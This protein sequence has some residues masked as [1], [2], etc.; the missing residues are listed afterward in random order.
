M[1]RKAKKSKR[2]NAI[3]MVFY[4]VTIF[5]LLITIAVPLLYAL[6][7]PISLNTANLVSTVSL[8][9]FLGT[10]AIS[11]M[12]H[13]RIKPENLTGELGL[14]RDRLTLKN[15]GYGILIFI[16][17][18]IITVAISEI[19]Q[20]THTS[21]NSNAASVLGIFPLW[22]LP[23]TMIL[24]P[25]NE[26]ILFR[27]FMVPRVGIVISA[28][29]FA[30]LHSGYASY[31]EFFMALWFGLVAGYAFKRTKSL[32]PSL[33]THMLVNSTTVLALVGSGMIAMVHIL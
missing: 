16:S 23:F 9:F 1:M 29:I 25:L 21:I 28:L 8:S 12:L 19:T 18:L 31:L 24:A 14:S 6:G 20:L 3:K 22:L 2:T 17:Y 10:V 15:I 7:Y 11:W 27:G 32:Y 26:E 33:V 5:A 30:A 13:K 4:S